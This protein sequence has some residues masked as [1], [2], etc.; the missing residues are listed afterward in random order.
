MKY[1]LFIVSVLLAGGTAHAAPQVFRG[2]FDGGNGQLAL[3]EQ[4]ATLSMDKSSCV[5]EVTNVSYA[6]KGN[7]IVLLNPSEE[8][9][10]NCHVILTVRGN[11]IISSYEEKCVA[12][13]VGSC[14]F[15]ITFH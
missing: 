1:M 12:K 13:Q 15:N 5:E 7:V 2:H 3:N 8:E 9:G 14:N 10:A 11:N 6:R 4:T